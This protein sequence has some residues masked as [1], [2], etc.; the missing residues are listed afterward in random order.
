MCTGVQ[1]SDLAHV[2]SEVDF[3]IAAAPRQRRRLPPSLTAIDREF[4]GVRPDRVSRI[5]N[6]TYLK[7]PHAVTD[8]I[9]AIQGMT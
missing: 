2:N 3:I 8:E 9:V 6:I 1:E 5:T 4:H 7:Q